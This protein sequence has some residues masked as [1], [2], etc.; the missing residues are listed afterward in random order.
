MLKGGIQHS[1]RLDALGDMWLPGKEFPKYAPVENFSGEW[2]MLPNWLAGTWVSVQEIETEFHDN[3]TG[4]SSSDIKILKTR[5]RESFGWQTDSRGEIWTTKEPLKPV[6]QEEPVKEVE[7]GGG[8]RTTVK[9]LRFNQPVEEAEDSISFK[10]KDIRIRIDSETNKIQSVARDENI[11]KLV[12]L[13]DDIIAV[14]SD[15][16]SYDDQGFPKGHKTIVAF[17]RKEHDFVKLDEFANRELRSSFSKYL[18]RTGKIY[19]I[20][21]KESS[22]SE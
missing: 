7:S 14:H 6:D 8:N 16:R 4:Q 3:K 18:Q 22:E 19:L 12:R 1:E 2:F 11:R 20:P 5:E 15:I 17:Y 9:L 10:S 21:E 13:G